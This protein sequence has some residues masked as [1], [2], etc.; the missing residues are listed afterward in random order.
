MNVRTLLTAVLALAVSF[1]LVHGLLFLMVTP[2][3]KAE[4]R[5]DVEQ[6]RAFCYQTTGSPDIVNAQAMGEHGGLHCLANDDGPHLHAYPE[7]AREDA[8][9]VNRSGGSFDAADY[10]VEQY[11]LGGMGSSLGVIGVTFV[12]VAGVGAV[13][14]LHRTY[15]S[16]APEEGDE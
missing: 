5:H 14:G 1:A 15:K 11:P 4:M 12:A 16:R 10:E 9:M 13:L 8:L 6:A 3:M 2:E 7:Q